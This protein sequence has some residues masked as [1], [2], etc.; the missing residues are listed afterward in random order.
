MYKVG[1]VP[2]KF[3]PP[4]RGHLYQIIQAATKCEKLFVVVSD[5]EQIVLDKCMKDHLPFIPIKKRALW[6]SIELQDFENI[7]VL[8]LDETGMPPYPHGIVPWAAA[9]TELIGAVDVIF[10]GE[11]EYEE[12]Y[13]PHF[14]GTKYEVFDYT[15]SRYPI[16][17]TEIRRNYLK[18]WDYILGAA[19]PFFCRRVLVTGPESCGKTTLTKYLAKIFHTSWSEERGRFFSTEN[20]GRNET[21]FS[22]DDFGEIAWQQVNHDKKVMSMANRVCFFDSDAVVTQFYCEMYTGQTNA[23][24][25][26][27]VDPNKFD[28][29]LLLGPQ[30]PWVA[31][32][33]R[34]KDKQEERERLYKRLMYMYLDRG[35]KD[36]IFYIEDEDYSMRLQRAISIVDRLL[37]SPEYLSRY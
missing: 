34:F 7:E 20:L 14:P 36:R 23:T 22:I 6:L 30:V 5:D 26:T 32:G 35:F 11:R 28:A 4:H 12:V 17:G 16:S 25:E 27:F 18:E 13:M 1:V 33:F 19:R 15:R 31:D 9:L 8:T 24:I 37:G 10:G 29:V 2:G 21:L 3:F